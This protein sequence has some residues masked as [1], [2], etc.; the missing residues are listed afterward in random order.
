[1]LGLTPA[2]IRPNYVMRDRP[3]AESRSQVHSL[4]YSDGTRSLY[5]FFCSVSVPQ[6]VTNLN[7]VGRNR[8]PP[9]V[10]SDSVG[11]PLDRSA[12]P[13]AFVG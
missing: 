4:R 6:S 9:G 5:G 3:D 7:L 10:K 13:Q 8:I 12:G 1:M 2:L 11:V